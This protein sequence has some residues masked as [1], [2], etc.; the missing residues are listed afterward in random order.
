WKYRVGQRMQ[1][2]VP[3]AEWLDEIV[4]PVDAVIRD[5]IESFVFQQ[6]GDRYERI[7]VHERHRDQYHVVVENDGAIFPGDVVVLRGAHQMQMALKS[8]SSGGVN[9]HAGHN[10]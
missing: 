5:G 2:G 9:P 3:V 8:K 1:L 4:L 6:N 7:S 10:H